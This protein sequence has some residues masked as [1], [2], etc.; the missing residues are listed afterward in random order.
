MGIGFQDMTFLGIL[1]IMSLRSHDVFSGMEG[2]PEMPGRQFS[3]LRN[4]RVGGQR[5]Q[6]CTTINL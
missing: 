1:S 6:L 4:K 3:Y 2:N 5:S